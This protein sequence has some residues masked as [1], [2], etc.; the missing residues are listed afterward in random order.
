MILAFSAGTFGQDPA[1]ATTPVPKVVNDAQEVTPDNVKGVPEI[2][3]GFEADS[4][5]LPDIGRVGV[6]MLSQKPLALREA[7]VKG[8]ENN[9]DIEVT[10]QE[11]KLAEFDLKAA[12]GSFEPRFKGQSFYERSTAPNISIFSSNKSTTL[13]TY[14]GTARYEAF[15]RNSGTT[16]F[17]EFT[18]QRQSTNNTISILSPQINTGLTVGF[19]QP[20]FS[21]RR[22]DDRRRVIEIAKKNL[23]MSDVEFRQ[24]AIEITSTIQRAYWDLT[25]ALKNLQVQRDGV[26]DAKEQLEHNKRLVSEGVLAPV[27]IIAAE[28]QVANLEQ[29]VY[30]ALETVNRY[31]NALKGLITGDKDDGIWAEALLPTDSVDLKVPLVT[32][33]D[34][35][36]SALDNRPELDSLGLA[37]D[38]NSINQKYYREQNKPQIDLTASYSTAGVSGGFNPNFQT[39]FQ[40]AACQA[41]PTSNACQTALAALNASIRSNAETFTGGYQSSLTD[42]FL[43]RYPTLSVGLTINL[44]LNGGKTSQAN[45]GKAL[46]EG[47]IINTR[48]KQI[49]QFIQIDVRNSLQ[50]MKTA[51]ARLRSAAVSRENSEKQYESEKRKLDAGMSDIYRVLERQTAL[52][53]A[54]SAE[55]QA[56]TELNKA[57]ADLQRAT[58]N[59]LKENDLETRL[60]K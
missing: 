46:V 34:A 47:E 27:D 55:I 20:L 21:G 8:L 32:L 4:T 44:P 40:P 1:P 37:K 49:E 38:I 14:G 60:V 35:L 2:G 23:S 28:T 10:R 17:G 22:F 31:E 11:V 19:V 52:M 29:I 33:D 13:S 50:S 42:I 58:G 54:R 7:I 25:F 51:E 53:N 39:P 3:K 26:R 48:R 45:L 41:D 43:N 30:V 12:D 5:K 16:Y 57:I 56:Q 6:D 24:K 36:A 18:N 15:L 59:S 9:I